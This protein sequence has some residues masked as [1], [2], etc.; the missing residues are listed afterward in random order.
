[1]SYVF[2]LVIFLGIPLGM[3]GGMN[4]FDHRR[5][6]RLPPS[7]E[8]IPA[9]WV[10]LSHVLVAVIYTTPWDNYLVAN[11]IWWYL[12]GRVVGLTLGWVPIEEYT[13]FILQSLLAGMWW[14]WLARRLPVDEQPFVNTSRIRWIIPALLGLIWLIV[15]LL[16]IS[17]W[18][19]FTYMGLI[20]VW[21]LP[22]IMIQTAVGA[23][24]MWH[25]RTLIATALISL[26]LYLAA[27]D[28]LAI[29]DGIWTIDPDQ[30]LQLY[31]NGVLPMEEFVFFLVTN[32]MLIFG[33]TLVM[34]AYTQQ[35]AKNGL[36]RTAAMVSSLSRH[37]DNHQR[38]DSVA[39][40]NL[41]TSDR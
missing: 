8:T 13:F 24:I 31:F 4:W 35:R 21:A 33:V 40:Q 26:T 29:N 10:I 7:L 16:L 1:M 36:H 22:A 23:D 30:S 2:F 19:A 25:Y 12:P 32:L 18:K 5:L 14:L 6:K 39:K 20:L 9:R 28:F 17:D 37:K 34:S 11:N 38:T 41:R 3:V 15:V 27:A